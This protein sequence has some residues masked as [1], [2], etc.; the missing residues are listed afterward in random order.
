MVGQF[1]NVYT[2]TIS[3]LSPLSEVGPSGAVRTCTNDCVNCGITGD[4]NCF[5]HP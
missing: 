2:L 4:N 1:D 3:I 5:I